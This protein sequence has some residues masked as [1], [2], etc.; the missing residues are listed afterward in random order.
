MARWRG[1]ELVA[2]LS[3]VFAK[4]V[5]LA[6]AEL[7]R[8][9]E[10]RF[11]RN[12]V[13]TLGLRC[14]MQA[15]LF[16]RFLP[17]LAALLLSE[18]VSAGELERRTW[19][20]DGVTREALI[21]L[22]EGAAGKGATLPVVFA[23]HGHGGSMDNASR[24]FPIHRL[25]PEAIVVY[26]QGLP[27][28]G[29]LTDRAGNRA[30]WQPRAG[31]EGDRD[32]KFFDAML[33]NLRQQYAVDDR[34]IYATGHSNGGGFTYLLWAERGETFA[35]LAPSSALLA[36]GYEKFRPKPLL[37]IGSPQDLLVRFAWQETMIDFVL[38]LDGCGPRQPEATG[39]TVY[40]SAKGAEVATY[41]HPGGHRF[42]S[43]ATEFIVNFFKAHVKT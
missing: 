12:R 11:Q 10:E 14:G 33:A 1:D 24:S 26:P 16:R 39:Y 6:R 34:R 43:A 9:L 13:R 21:S 3:N 35:A 38:K 28:A 17:L 27:T 20:V 25:W 2:G 32:L 23:F 15:C 40:P 4:V 29:V 18:G 30:G 22:P 37:H 19:T 7:A 31:A 5:E 8:R 41:L 42:P 36:R